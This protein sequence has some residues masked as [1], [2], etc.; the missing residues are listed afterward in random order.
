MPADAGKRCEGGRQTVL[1]SATLTPAV[2]AACSQWCPNLQ[3][4]V[5]GPDATAAALDDAAAAPMPFAHPSQ[6]SSPE[7]TQQAPQWGWD[8]DNRQ[9]DREYLALGVPLT[10]VEHLSSMAWHTQPTLVEHSRCV[11]Y[12]ATSRHVAVLQCTGSQLQQAASAQAG[13]ALP[14]HIRH[15]YVVTP[16]HR[17]VDL[18]RRTIHALDAQRCLVFMNFQQRLKVLLWVLKGTFTVE[19]Q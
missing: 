16:P 10:P 7:V 8:T 11:Q 14:P 12:S 3:P 17:R 15:M 5:V 1:V 19:K 13:A 2:L 6:H 9:P 4:V 18:L